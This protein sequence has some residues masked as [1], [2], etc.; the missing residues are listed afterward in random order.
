MFRTNIISH[1]KNL[2]GIFLFRMNLT[3]CKLETPK[4]DLANSA[5]PDQTLQNVASDQGLH[6]STAIFLLEYLN[7]IA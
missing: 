1:N 7:H 6:F 3:Y 2:D 4:R 5:D